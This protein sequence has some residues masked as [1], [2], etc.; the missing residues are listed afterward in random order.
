[1]LCDQPSAAD[2]ND[3]IP[4]YVAR[5]NS[6]IAKTLHPLAGTVDVH[7]VVNG[8]EH[9]VRR[10]A[11]DGRVLLKIGVGE[12]QSTS[13]TE[14][15]NLLPIQAYS[16]KQL[17]SVAVRVDELIRFLEAPGKAELASVDQRFD[18]LA[19]QIR[20]LHAARLQH[21]LLVR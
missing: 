20:E 19:V 6:L 14:V 3:E 1:A 13:D 9:V 7:F 2:G 18:Q 17:S 4:D 21:R 15:R 11:A 10:T 5:R 12:F 8:V 16:Q